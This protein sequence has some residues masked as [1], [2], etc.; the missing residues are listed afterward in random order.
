MLLDIEDLTK[1]FNLRQGLATTQLIAVDQ[2][3]FSLKSDQPEIFALAG[4]SGSGK[5]R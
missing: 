2:A 1:I 3:N 4:E 5:P